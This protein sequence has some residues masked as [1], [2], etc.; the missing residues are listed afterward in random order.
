VSV[1][2]PLPASVGQC[3]KYMIMQL[4][5]V[6]F[7]KLIVDHRCLFP[8]RITKRLHLSDSIKCMLLILILEGLRTWLS[9]LLSCLFGGWL[10]LN[11]GIR[12][13]IAS[14]GKLYRLLF[15][16]RIGGRNSCS[17]HGLGWLFSDY[18]RARNGRWSNGS[19]SAGGLR[20][21]S[22]GL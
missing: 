6:P 15:L 12:G 7:G 1:L 19:L 5:V 3:K 14:L 16:K 11:I 21:S 4:S 13:V 2:S 10:N 17:V 20:S 9:S 8:E 18:I 22:S